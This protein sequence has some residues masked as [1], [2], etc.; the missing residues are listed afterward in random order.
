MSFAHFSV[1]FLQQ[2]LVL[3]ICVAVGYTE[4]VVQWSTLA[5]FKGPNGVDV[6][7][8]HLRME[9]DPVSRIPDDG[10]SP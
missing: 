5:L 7:P 8:P 2:S 9:T 1:I 4:G 3:V 6:F 10:Q